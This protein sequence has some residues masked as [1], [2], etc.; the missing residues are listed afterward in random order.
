MSNRLQTILETV[1]QILSEV[2]GEEKPRR[3]SRTYGG[4][5][6]PA[7]RPGSR[8]D[9]GVGTPASHAEN[10]AGDRGRNIHRVA[11]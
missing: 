9:G 5:S 4:R 8:G 10:A 6:D 1:Q 3:R 7:P 2:K 11:R